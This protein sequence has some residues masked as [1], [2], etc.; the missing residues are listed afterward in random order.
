M[1]FERP[2]RSKEKRRGSREKLRMAT[3]G[4]RRETEPTK[5]EERNTFG[6]SNCHIILNIQVELCN[7]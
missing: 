4:L 6:A 5:D 3:Q 7:C 2:Q 1:V